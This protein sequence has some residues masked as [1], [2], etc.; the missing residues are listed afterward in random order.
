[1]SLPHALLTSLIEK[2]C[3][4]YELARRFDKSIGYFWHA[5]HQQIYRELARMEENG[6]VSSSEVEGG[7]AGKK[8]FEVLPAGRTELQRWAAESTAPMRLRDDMLV[9]LR[10]DAAVGAP[11]LIEEMER[12]LKLHE[13][14]LENYKAI[15]QRDFSHRPLLREAQI[16]YLILQAGISFEESRVA[17]TKQALTTLRQQQ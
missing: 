14:E 1:M 2:P 5:T 16:H 3:S 9:R 6:W 12:R 11:G 8:R 15:E 13:Q 10:A 17:W 7:R 4:G